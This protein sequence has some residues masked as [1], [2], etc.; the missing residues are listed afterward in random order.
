MWEKLGSKDE[1]LKE[2]GDTPV[3]KLV[4]KIVGLD[5]EAANEA[6]SEF[7]GENRLNEKQR[8]FVK[9]IIDYVV[10]NGLMEDRRTLQQE[11]FRA[12]GSVVDLFKNNMNDAKSIL[13]IVDEIGK[14]SEEIV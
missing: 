7:L 2:F 1:Y 12:V 11:P 5:R 3:N 13:D 9:L 10:A 8:H 4:R 14:N 6:F